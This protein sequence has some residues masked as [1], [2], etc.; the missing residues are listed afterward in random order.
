MALF[1]RTPHQAEVMLEQIVALQP[2]ELA[3]HFP[4]PTAG[5]LRHGDLRVVIADSPWHSAEELKRPP[6]PFQER[7]GAF[8][9]EY[10]AEDG[11]AVRQRHHE[12]SHTG[13]LAP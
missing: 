3:G 10:L 1:V 7:F 13:R 5:D 6:V 12:Q 2:K 11:V 8:A 4:L 9:R